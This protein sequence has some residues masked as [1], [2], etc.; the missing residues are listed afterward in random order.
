[1]TGVVLT[2][3]KGHSDSVTKLALSPDGS[4]VASGSDDNTTKLWHTRSGILL[5]TLVGHTG[6]ILRLAF[7]PDGKLIASESA[8]TTIKIWNTT[9][10]LLQQTL[11]G[12]FKHLTM[13]VFLPDSTSLLSGAYDVVKSRN[14]KSGA[15][16]WG[17]E[18]RRPG[19]FTRILLSPN[20][21]LVAAQF[22]SGQLKLLDARSGELLRTIHD[23]DMYEEI[24]FSSD[25]SALQAYGKP[26][27]V[28]SS[29]SADAPPRLYVSV[30]DDWI[31]WGTERILWLPP[32]YRTTH[33]LVHESIVA[34]CLTQRVVFLEFA[35]KE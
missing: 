1:M 22:I 29:K 11:G 15:I 18:A 2:T 9:S 8:D 28:I 4:L 16:L 17:F 23:F 12:S 20:S 13:L 31:F 26:P 3:L 21:K 14:A 33:C 35:F 10:G 6:K 27:F 19:Y 30:D 32:E 7:S 5:R 24:S 34:I 25:S